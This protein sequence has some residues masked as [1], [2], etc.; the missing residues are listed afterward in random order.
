[1]GFVVSSVGSFW[2]ATVDR[3][4]GTPGN[5]HKSKSESVRSIRLCLGA[6]AC[7]RISVDMS[8]LNSSADVLRD[9]HRRCGFTSVRRGYDSL[10]P[11]RLKKFTYRQ[12]WRPYPQNHPQADDRLENIKGKPPARATFNR[13][14]SSLANSTG[15][16]IRMRLRIYHAISALSCC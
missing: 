8:A 13:T 1:M 3:V 14:R 11:N 9:R 5:R 15:K 6:G 16:Q 2:Y 10:R 4:P 12:S 7:S